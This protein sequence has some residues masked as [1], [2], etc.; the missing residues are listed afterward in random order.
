LRERE[1]YKETAQGLIDY[2]NT[3]LT[4]PAQPCFWGCQ[5]YVRPE[6][7]PPPSH[8]SGPLP[9]L[10]LLDQ[11]VYC[12][13]NARAASSYLDAWWLLGRDDCR[14]RAEQILQHPWETLRAPTREMYHYWDE[15][16]HVPGRLLATT[17]TG[18]AMRDAYA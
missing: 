4:D 12:D 3:T 5:D 1:A 16:P 17:L 11:Y 9:L 10:W 18:V 2:L 13:A 15:A 14:N 8:S 6:L 7:P